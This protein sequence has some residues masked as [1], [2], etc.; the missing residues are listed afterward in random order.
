VTYE[1]D[2]TSYLL[3]LFILREELRRTYSQKGEAKQDPKCV[4]NNNKDDDDD[5]G[6]G[7]NGGG[8]SALSALYITKLEY[9]VPVYSN[10]QTHIV[11]NVSFSIKLISMLYVICRFSN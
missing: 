10:S 5:D 6:G 1:T 11:L 4:D 7:G 2:M 8:E 3:Q 9:P